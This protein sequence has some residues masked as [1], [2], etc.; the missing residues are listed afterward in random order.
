MFHD[1][2]YRNADGT[3]Q[4]WRRNG[5]TKVWKTRPDTTRTLDRDSLATVDYYWR[6]SVASVADVLAADNPRFDRARF[7]R[8]CRPSD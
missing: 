3:C 4:R 2:T 7:E 6:M 5:R 8:A 1:N